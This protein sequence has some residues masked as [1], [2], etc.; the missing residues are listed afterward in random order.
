M[1]LTVANQK[2]GTGKTTLAFNLAVMRSRRKSVL[3]LDLDPQESLTDLFTIRQRS[4]QPLCIQANQ[5]NLIDDLKK[6]TGDFDDVVLDMPGQDN[7]ILLQTLLLS[8]VFLVPF[9]ASRL[10]FLALENMDSLA[11][12]VTKKNPGLK[13]LAVL[14]MAPT[15]AQE[16]ETRKIRYQFE[17][18]RTLK[19]LGFQIYDRTVYRTTVD[20]GH[21]IIESTNEKAIQEINNLYKRVFQDAKKETGRL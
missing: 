10:D 2:G 17:K 4:P 18:Y 16:K 5:S 19:L 7:D 9:R 21:V 20:L 14:S 8:D 12:A 1:I 15:H 13:S 11:A 6:A 3:A